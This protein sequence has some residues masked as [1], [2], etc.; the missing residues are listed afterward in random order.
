MTLEEFFGTISENPIMILSF[1][2]LIPLTAA[3]AGFMGKGEGHLSPWKFL[4]STLIYLVCVPGI[5]AIA[6]NFY[7]FLFERRS[8]F[9]FDIFTQILPIISMVA[10][11]LFVRKNVSLDR[12]P[13]FNKI[14]G[15]F[16]MI[17][18]GLI[19]M[20][21]LDRT[22]IFVVAFT[23]MPFY[24]VGFIFV[25]LLVLLRLGMSKVLKTNT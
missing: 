10:T 6:L 11:L 22:R 3:I 12:I 5:L 4:Y 23:Q 8:I 19:L 15:L 7:T 1:F 20:W 17:F 14:S 13:G 21:I 25:G 2:L 9:K 24:Y 18:A 16:M